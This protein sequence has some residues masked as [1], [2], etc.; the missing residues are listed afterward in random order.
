MATQ[1][2]A[3]PGRG[4]YR[5]RRGEMGGAW[6][7]MS[8]IT[9]MLEAMF[10]RYDRMAQ[11]VERDAALSPG[12]NQAAFRQQQERW[13]TENE[14]ARM[15]KDQFKVDQGRQRTADANAKY[16]RQKRINEA[17]YDRNLA[18]AT[19]VT[20]GP[21]SG[22][23]TPHQSEAQLAGWGIEGDYQLTKDG[24]T[25]TPTSSQLASLGVGPDVRSGGSG[26]I[27][28]SQNANPQLATAS[29]SA[30]YGAM[31]SPARGGGM[32]YAPFATDFMADFESASIDKE[33][34]RGE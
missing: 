9:P 34:K 20:A 6:E 12:R 32:S 4:E 28:V 17:Y 25:G 33:K 18:A 7:F 5:N 8:G 13:D 3:G 30:A 31:M 11:I 19:G 14:Q 22:M 1:V 15:A 24:M 29:P 27:Y 21:G 23:T 10:N 26:G 2:P 16:D